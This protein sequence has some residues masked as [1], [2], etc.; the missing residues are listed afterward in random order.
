MAFRVG[1]LYECNVV[2]CNATDVSERHD[3]F[4]FRF[5]G[6]GPKIGAEAAI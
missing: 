1:L 5:E 3:V 4:F 2:M 6:I